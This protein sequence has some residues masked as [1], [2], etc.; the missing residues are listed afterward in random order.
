MQKTYHGSCHCDAVRYEAQIDFAQGTGKCNCRFCTK[1]RNWSARADPA[2]FRVTQGESNLG[3]RARQGGD[4]SVNH[5]HCRLCATHVFSQGRIPEMGG[6]FVSVRVATLDDA[7]VDELM[8]GPV[9][10]ADGR[11]DDWMHVP[12]ETRHL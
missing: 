3:E 9:R 7:S 1:T 4:A 12:Q 2:T 11:N 6:D 8:S 5:R 10:H